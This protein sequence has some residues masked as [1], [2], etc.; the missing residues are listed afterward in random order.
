MLIIKNL[1]VKVSDHEILRGINLK[2]NAG[3]VHAIMGPNG[4]G[5][6]T[7][8]GVLAG[9]DSYCV[10]RGSVEFL[11]QD[12]FGLKIE[13]R[14][15]RGIFLALQYPVEM[16]GVNNMYFIRTA[17]NN[18]RN[19]QGLHALDAFDFMSLVKEKAKLLNMDES[20]LERAFNVGFSGGEKK[21]NEILQMLLLEPKFAVLDEIDSGLDIDALRVIA[22][23][24]NALRDNKRAIL[25]V[26]H[27]Q[28]L[29]QYIIPDF[30]HVMIKGQIVKSGAKELAEDLERTGYDKGNE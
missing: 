15:W 14:A 30:V 2:I 29:L 7:L 20:F 19:K 26:T 23:G 22:R 4:S 16:P 25:L 27:Y 24:V 3:E 28:R 12:L 9:N 6:S 1:H 8:A 10:T 18:L 17:L 21:R 13:E 5:K 11:G